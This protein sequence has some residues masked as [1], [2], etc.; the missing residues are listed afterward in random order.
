[1]KMINKKLKRAGIIVNIFL[2]IYS[3]VEIVVCLIEE[4]RKEVR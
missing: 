2:V 3:F 1:M 4:G